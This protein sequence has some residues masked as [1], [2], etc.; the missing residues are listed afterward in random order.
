MAIATSGANPEHREVDLRDRPRALHAISPK[1]TVPVLQFADG[2]VLD[3]SLDIMNWCLDQADPNTWRKPEHASATSELIATNDGEFKQALDRFKYDTRYEDSD[4]VAARDRAMRFVLNLEAR[5][6]RSDY[7]CGPQITLA[8]VAVFPFVRQFARADEA[9][10]TT[11]PCER[12]RH[13]LDG[14]EARPLFRHVMQKLPIWQPADEPKQ[15]RSVYGA[16][17]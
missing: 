4:P 2:S 15:F 10:F 11:T 16:L 17:G 14:W 6:L 3:E 12:V 8:D 9:W 1:A 7:M 5:L 13:W